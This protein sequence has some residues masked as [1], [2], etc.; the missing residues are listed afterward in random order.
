MP[1][2]IKVA[3]V[4][5]GFLP[6][7]PTKGGA[8]ESLVQYIANENEKQRR[9]DL[10]V[11]TC[12][13][14]EALR[15]SA[16]LSETKFKFVKTP[17]P[18]RTADKVIYFFAKYVLR[19]SKHLSYR[20]ILQ[21]LY[22]I[23]AVG[24]ALSKEA[25]DRVVI[26][27]HPTLLG[28][29]KI[30]GNR[31]RYKDRCIYH[32]HNELPGLFGCEHEFLECRSVMGVSAY[33]LSTLDTLFAGRYSDER[34]KVLRNRVDSNELVRSATPDALSEARERYGIPA[35]AKV[36]LFAGR[37]CREKGALELI[38]AFSRIQHQNSV[39]LIAGSYYF[40]TG[41]RSAYEER[42]KHGALAL[43]SRIVF[44]GFIPHGD[45]GV[46]Y[47][48]ADVVVVPSLWEDPAPLSVVEPLTVG[49]PLV[50]TRRGGI[51]EYATDGAD[52]VVL[53]VEDN[54][55]DNMARSID[56]ILAGS[57]KLQKCDSYDLSLASFYREYVE[58]VMQ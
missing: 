25:V 17:L 35:E 14:E 12:F 56:G 57:I 38:E 5:S 13:D 16:E 8:V 24:K 46:L 19:K 30:A 34:M 2:R 41:M 36:V 22:F 27:N 1:E 15:R 20:Y 55:V 39:L 9:L 53:D 48:L 58:L 42:L 32:M 6:V 44:T 11:Y 28:I 4:T 45:M 21:R 31:K 23:R 33:I 3:I 52:S 10:V 49:R 47:A 43:G 51:P 54:F 29:L 50:T 18:I 7:P 40:D 37:L 26:E